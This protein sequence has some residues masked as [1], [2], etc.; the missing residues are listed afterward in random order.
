MFRPSYPTTAFVASA[1]LAIGPSLTAAADS[2]VFNFTTNLTAYDGPDGLPDLSPFTPGTALNALVNGQGGFAGLASPDWLRFTGQI[3]ISDFQGDGTYVVS[4]TNGVGGIYLHSPLLN[5]LEAVS[6]RTEGALTQDSLNA[7][8]GRT[9]GQPTQNRDDIY[10]PDFTPNGTATVVVSGNDVSIDYLLDFTTLPDTNAGFLRDGTT[11]T[12]I[13]GILEAA[14]QQFETIGV[15]G[16]GTAAVQSATIGSGSEDGFA[17]G[18]YTLFDAVTLGNLSNTITPTTRGV[19][20]NEIA[21]GNISS[22]GRSATNPATTFLT[23][24]FAGESGTTFVFDL[25]SGPDFDAS[26]T[27]IPEPASLLTLL[28]G[29]GLVASRRRTARSA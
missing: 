4:P 9:D 25:T 19:I 20:D 14:G 11:P 24:P 21:A 3:Y 22:D 13:S 1:I 28:A 12:Q 8:A 6:L 5:R 15:Q 10:L 29:M 16:F 7:G 23:D 27:L 17:Y 2:A 18:G 26:A